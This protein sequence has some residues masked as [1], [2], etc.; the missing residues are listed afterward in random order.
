MPNSHSIYVTRRIPDAGLRLLTDAGVRYMI[1]ESDDERGLDPEA[2]RAGVAAADVLVSLLTDTIDRDVL[3][4]NSRLRGVA[5]YAVGYNNI[6]L[7]AATELGIPVSNT[8]GVLTEAT[9]DLTWALLLAVA[10]RVPQADAYMR[11]GRYGIW[12]PNLLLG[13]DVGTGPNGERKTL[14]II[15]YGRIGAAVARRARGFDMRVLAWTRSGAARMAD[16]DG[17]E[18]AERERVLHESDY[19][20]VHVALAPETRHLIDGQALRAMKRTAY[21]IN[22]TRGEVVDERALVEALRTG[23]IAGAGLDVYEDEPRMAPGLANCPN[24]VLLPHI[25]SATHATRDRMAVLAA[26]NAL[27][28]MRGERAPNCVNP[29]VYQTAAFQERQ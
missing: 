22:T 5:N 28:H 4:A 24:T 19:V 25:G 2:L 7:E 12:G 13:S 20:S 15:G 11:S 23:W 14:G 29:S 9:A 18:Y 6:D 26:T 10:R 17:V 27:A 3:S 1:G 16:D 8:P 21:L